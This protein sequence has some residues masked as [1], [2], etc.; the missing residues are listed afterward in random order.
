MPLAAGTWTGVIAVPTVQLCA[1]PVS[2]VNEGATAAGASSA[3]VASLRVSCRPSAVTSWSVA[4]SAKSVSGSSDIS[5]VPAVA[6]AI[7]S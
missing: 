7:R 6:D 3:I 2:S 5:S 4:V 1:S